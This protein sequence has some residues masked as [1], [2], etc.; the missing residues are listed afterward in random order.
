MRAALLAGACSAVQGARSPQHGGSSTVA[1]AAPRPV[2]QPQQLQGTLR[3]RAAVCASAAA[4]SLDGILAGLLELPPAELEKAVEDA[5]L[6]TFWGSLAAPRV[7]DSFRNLQ[8][9]KE[10]KK[11]WPGLGLQ[12]ANS[13]LEGLSAVPFPDPYSG[14]YKW[15]EALEKQTPVILQEF[16]EVTADPELER[17]GNNI[18]VPAVR[19]DAAGYGDDWRTL[20]LQD[21]GYWDEDNEKL[22]P[23]TAKIFQDMDAPTLEVFFAR[24]PPGTG[25]KRHTDYVNFVQTTHLG[26]I[27]P[28]GDCWMKVGEHVRNWEVGKV[29]ICETSYY[30]E[31]FNNTSD[32]RIV[33]IMRHCHP[34]VTKV[35]RLAIQFLFDCLDAPTRPG[36]AAAQAKAQEALAA[37]SSVAALTAGKGKGK[38]KGGSGGKSGGGGFGGGGSSGGKGFGA[39]GK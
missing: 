36:I 9:G 23:K 12:H 21:R 5:F 11:E 28:E 29:M 26:L 34:E 27:V 17:K 14:S 31:T 2:W 30:H 8:A 33:L 25:V 7:L 38:K 15:L 20:V 6:D 3:R 1:A 4:P 10:L 13:Y 35:E 16:L 19:G 22:F 24:Q 18:W 37:F 39:K 32:T